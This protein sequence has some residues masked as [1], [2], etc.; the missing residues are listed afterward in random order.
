MLRRAKYR[1]LEVGCSYNFIS[2]LSGVSSARIQFSRSAEFCFSS[3][4]PC[5]PVLRAWQAA[6]SPKSNWKRIQRSPQTLRHIS[7]FADL[8]ADSSKMRAPLGF[9]VRHFEKTLKAATFR[10][11]AQHGR[12]F[13]TAAVRCSFR[14]S[15]EV[16]QSSIDLG[17]PGPCLRAGVNHGLAPMSFRAG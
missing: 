17:Q 16:K 15:Q 7:R 5:L 14:P 4:I 2:L 1:L 8:F 12:W 13:L 6:R 9:R 10:S 11:S 3:M